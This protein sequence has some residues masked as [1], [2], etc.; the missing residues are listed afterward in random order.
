V[1]ART[2]TVIAAN[3]FARA[4]VPGPAGAPVSRNRPSESAEQRVVLVVPRA[5]VQV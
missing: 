4:S 1:F 2:S 5:F 3:A